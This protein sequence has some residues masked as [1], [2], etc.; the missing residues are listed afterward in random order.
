M[1]DSRPWVSWHINMNDFASLNTESV[2]EIRIGINATEDVRFLMDNISFERQ[3]YVLDF[4]KIIKTATVS[5]SSTV[6]RQKTGTIGA[7]WG[8]SIVKANDKYN[9]FQA[10]WTSGKN[11]DTGGIDFLQSDKLTSGYVYVNSPLPRDFITTIPDWGN[12][13]HNP[14][15]VKYGDTYYLYYSSGRST[16]RGGNTREIG[17]AWSKEITG[18]WTFSQGPVI[19]K[20]QHGVPIN[21]DSFNGTWCYGV[22]NPRMI[23]K[24]GEYYMFYKT[25]HNFTLPKEGSEGRSGSTGYYLGY[26]IAKSN[27]PLGPFTQIRNSGLRGRGNQYALYPTLTDVAIEGKI[28]DYSAP[29]LWDLEDMCIFKY[30]DGRYYGILKDF[31]G[32]W[33]RSGNPDDLT[34]FVSDNLTDWRVADFPFVFSITRTP[35]FATGYPTQYRNLERP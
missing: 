24:D 7:L 30:I 4:T 33:N 35:Y 18:G 11:F 27:S 31:M 12:Y 10:W 28:A 15:I 21:D 29:G 6:I 2:K 26:S 1:M 23:E 16:D 13:A 3:K 20:E 8:T 5:E 34:L 22:E 32:R 25:L 17:V 14:D 9:L 19:T